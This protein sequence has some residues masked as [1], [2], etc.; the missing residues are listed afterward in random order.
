MANKD[1]KYTWSEDDLEL[2]SEPKNPDKKVEE[3]FENPE[4]NRISEILDPLDVLKK[5]R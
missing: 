2:V 3:V 1:D 4:K 5:N